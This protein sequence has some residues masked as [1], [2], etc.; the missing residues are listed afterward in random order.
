MKGAPADP[1]TWALFDVDLA[2]TDEDELSALIDDC[3]DSGKSLAFRDSRE[4]EDVR[5]VC[6]S[7]EAYVGLVSRALPGPTQEQVNTEVAKDVARDAIR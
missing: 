1:P 2:S 4:S 7:W 3:I 6:I 5:A